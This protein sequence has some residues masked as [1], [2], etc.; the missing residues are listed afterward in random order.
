MKEL[1]SGYA[2]AVIYVLLTIGLLAIVTCWVLNQR[3]A[4]TLTEDS[5][6]AN[7]EQRV[8]QTVYGRA[9][10]VLTFSHEVALLTG[11]ATSLDAFFHA[12]DA[13]GETLNVTV[14]SVKDE[15]GENCEYPFTKPG[16][17]QVL[18]YAEDSFH[19]YS[20]KLFHIP[21]NRGEL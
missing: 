3:N 18:V 6:V 17:Y 9:E 14:A 13:D 16:V 19:V 12:E 2:K 8:M 20:R 7:E 5:Y 1:M 4:L 21:V 11:E 10:P 15:R